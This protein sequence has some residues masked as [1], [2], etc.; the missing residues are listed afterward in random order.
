MKVVRQ[1]LISLATTGVLLAVLFIS[2]GRASY[3]QAWM[4]AAISVLMSLLTRLVLRHAPDLAEERAK[5]GQGAMTWDKMLLGVELLLTVATLVVAGLDSGRFHWRPRLSWVWVPVGI[6]LNLA[7]MA[8]F[9]LALRVNR[10]FSAV[11]RIQT[12]RGQTVCTTGPYRVVRHPGNAGMIVGLLGFPLLF[13]SAWSFVPVLLSVA[14]MVVRTRLEDALLE[15]ELDGYSD[16]MRTTH[17][18]LLPGVW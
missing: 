11:V 2:A 16:Y 1:L 12:D 10:F 5:P 14:V 3:W 13:S 15:N 4:Y 18:R 17:F 6:G 9:L 8:M 7:G